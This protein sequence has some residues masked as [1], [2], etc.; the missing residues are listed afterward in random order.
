MKGLITYIREYTKESTGGIIKKYCV[1]P[2][3]N[4]LINYYEA[5]AEQEGVI[6]K[7]QVDLPTELPLSDPEFC[8]LIGNIME[9]A[10]HAA[11][12]APTA[13]RNFS[14]SILVQNDS[15]LYIVSSNNYNS[16][17]I[18]ESTNSRAF[19]SL[20]KE[21]LHGIGLQSIRET[22]DKFNG[23]LRISKS[24]SEFFLDIAIRI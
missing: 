18:Q 4:A 17:I 19:P 10:I 7:I 12:D 11:K 3:I 2:A 15:T 9:N 20:K 23:T 1:N 24:D 22:V 5:K 14:I 6:T 16:Q 13:K 8:A 21:K